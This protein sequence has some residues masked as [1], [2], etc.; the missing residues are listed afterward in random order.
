MIKSAVTISLV[1]E[2]QG[3]PFVFWG[4]LAGSC[5][6]AAALGFD[7]VEIFAPS[8]EAL[9]ARQLKQ[10]LTQHRLNLAALGTGGGWVLR[11]LRLTDLVVVENGHSPLVDPD[12]DMRPRGTNAINVPAVALQPPPGFGYPR[13]EPGLA[14]FALMSSGTDVSQF[15]VQIVFSDTGQVIYS[16]P[17]VS[18]DLGR[19]PLVVHG[20][21]I[22]LRN[23]YFPRPGLYE[24]LLL[25]NG[26]ELAREPLVMRMP[27]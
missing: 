21:P 26:A 8:A 12:L 17:E 7:A 9:D 22:E 20:W 14:L 3:G 19:D 1:P 10:L 11:K 27:L 23:L 4:D 2:A 13:I 5:A 15:R 25:C 16:S 24:F 6:K 18:R